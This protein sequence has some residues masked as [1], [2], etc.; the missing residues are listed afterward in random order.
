M[1]DE[2]QK[3]EIRLDFARLNLAGVKYLNV[4]ELT[5]KAAKV[6]AAGEDY[7]TTHVSKETWLWL[8]DI[9]FCT[10][11]LKWRVAANGPNK[12]ILIICNLSLFRCQQV[13]IFAEWIAAGY[14]CC[15]VC[16]Q[17]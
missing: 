12:Q 17:V 6:R 2:G 11:A 1:S 4:E 7:F 16:S 9:N 14:P 15:G 5:I 3:D 13:K 10:E 8:H